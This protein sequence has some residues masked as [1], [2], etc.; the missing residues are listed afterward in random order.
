[1]I[2]CHP[3]IET[4]IDFS[5]SGIPSLVI[6]RPDFFRLLMQDFYE[7]MDG[8]TGEFVLSENGKEYEVGTWI[9]LIDNCLHFSLNT[10]TLLVKISTALEKNA[11]NEAN[12]LK[13]S[14]ILQEVERYIEELSFDFNC[15]IECKHCSISGLIKAVG[16]ALR[17]EYEN[18]MERLIDYM[19][20]IRE[21]D[22]DKVFVLV[23]IRSFFDDDPV[24]QFLETLV[25][26]GYRVLLLDSV[27]R[28]LLSHERRITID[29]DLCEF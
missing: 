12:F 14:S 26:H 28:K 7:Q 5:V 16:I 22:K 3:Q 1:M 23:N 18:P 25:T 21:F 19:E 13:T 9:E 24:D 4:L 20:L 27:C 10:K 8:K 6:E 17:D 15:D 2:L 11:V 29:N